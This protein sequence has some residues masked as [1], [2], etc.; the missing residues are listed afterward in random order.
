MAHPQGTA[1]ATPLCSYSLTIT[2]SEHAAFWLSAWLALLLV[3]AAPV[4]L[5]ARPEL[6]RQLLGVEDAL[7]H[8][9]RTADSARKLGGDSLTF[10]HQARRMSAACAQA[11]C[12]CAEAPSTTRARA[13]ARTLRL[14]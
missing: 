4:A 13:S 10:V 5:R 11:L 14:G 9:A 12:R 7:L 1:A 8:E 3:L 6:R 2:Q